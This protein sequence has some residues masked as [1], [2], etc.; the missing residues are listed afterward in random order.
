M[1]KKVGKEEFETLMKSSKTVLVDFSASWCGP[2]QMMA[3]LIDDLA[4]D[5]KDN[6][7]VEVIKLDIDENPDITARYKVMGV[8]TFIVFKD[9]EEKARQVGATT[10]ENLEDKIK[11]NL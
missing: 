4:K 9:G 7:Q 11:D 1:A 2:C 10:K 8:P 5:F 3:P 6:D